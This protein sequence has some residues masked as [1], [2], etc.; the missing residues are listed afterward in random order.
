MGSQQQFLK[1]WQCQLRARRLFSG[2]SDGSESEA[3][4]AAGEEVTR[5]GELDLQDVEDEDALTLRLLA[6]K[7]IHGVHHRT[8][9]SFRDKGAPFFH[10]SESKP[11]VMLAG[12]TEP[13]PPTSVSDKGLRR[14]S[15]GLGETRN[16]EEWLADAAS[17]I[18]SCAGCGSELATRA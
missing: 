4:A 10:L 15:L 9:L 11:P 12:S 2:G 16:V 6:N 7:R 14:V 17:D 5:M 1:D 8:K 18:L 13:P 3:T